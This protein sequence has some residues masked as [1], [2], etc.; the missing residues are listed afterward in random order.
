MESGLGGSDILENC[1]NLVSDQ[2]CFFKTVQI[3]FCCLHS[4]KSRQASPE[5]LQIGMLPSSPECFLVPE[6]LSSS[7]AFLTSARIIYK[8]FLVQLLL[9]K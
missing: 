7:S 2:N 8:S 9:W 4:T 1:R 6:L 5:R 3:R